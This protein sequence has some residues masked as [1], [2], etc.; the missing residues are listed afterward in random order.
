MELMERSTYRLLVLDS[1]QEACCADAI[2]IL[3]IFRAFS[4]L[5]KDPRI[6]ADELSI[7]DGNMMLQVSQLQGP[8]V[9][10][11]PDKSFGRGFIMTYSGPFEQIEPRRI[12][13]VQHLTV[14]KFS[15]IYILRDEI[16]EQIAC[17]LYPHLYRIENQLRS[18]LTKF[19]LTQIGPS[20]W[21]R[22]VPQDI[23]NK[24]KMRK[25]NEVIFGK[26]LKNDAYLVDFNELGEIIYKQSS[27]FLTKE[28]IIDR[29]QD[30]PETV[31][32]LKKL[33]DDLQTNYQKFF[34][35]SFAEKDFQEKW[36]AFERLRNKIAHG[37][38]FV[39]DDLKQG[40]MLASEITRIIDSADDKA[41]KLAIVSPADRM[42]LEELSA[43]R[44]DKDDQDET[45]DSSDG[46]GSI[47]EEQ[48]LEMLREQERYF[49]DGFVG[50]AHFKRI[51]EDLGYHFRAWRDMIRT[52]EEKGKVEVYKVTN[53]WNE[54][55]VSAIRT[56]KI[57]NPLD[58]TEM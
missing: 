11:A 55:L 37:N 19:M 36:K 42:V 51:L 39:I 47:S 32:D 29:V 58:A 40:E 14:Q 26:Y 10:C 1:K 20:W 4:E 5:W 35:D 24:V 50:L 18:Y 43:V 17:Q 48:L 7:V 31:D 15:H 28:D 44:V 13:L 2:S 30:L 21:D 12:L 16:S 25:S 23:V 9:K 34:K 8:S 41:E 3:H 56:A 45:E 57:T 6:A 54:H 52:L 46:S 53:P 27:G 33:K 38:I 22:T 49:R